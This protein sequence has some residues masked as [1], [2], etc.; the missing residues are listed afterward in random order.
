MTVP[1][2]YL[3]VAVILAL[4]LGPLLLLMMFLDYSHGALSLVSSTISMIDSKDLAGYNSARVIEVL[5]ILPQDERLIVSVGLMTCLYVG[6]FGEV[7]PSRYRWT[8]RSSGEDV[9]E[10]ANLRVIQKDLTRT[11][12]IKL[13]GA[14]HYLFYETI[15]ISQAIEYLSSSP[16][17]I[18][19]LGDFN[20]YMPKGLTDIYDNIVW[21]YSLDEK[22][23]QDGIF[24]SDIDVLFGT[25]CVDPRLEWHLS[26][27]SPLRLGRTANSF[28]SL[29]K[30]FAV[31][32]PKDMPKLRVDGQNTFKIVQL[33][34]LHFSVGEGRCRDEFPKH[35][36]CH[37]DPKTTSFIEQVLDSEKPNLVVFTGDQIMGDECFPDSTS[38]LLKVVGP[39]IER[40]IPYAMVWG[41]HDDEGSLDRWQLS[42]LA[43][44]LPYS[45]FKTSDKDTNDNT[46]GVGNYAHHIY[47]QNDNPISALYFLDAHKYSPNAKAYPGYDWIKEEQWK[48]FE[49]YE[50]FF[51]NQNKSLSMAFFHIPLPE[52]LNFQSKNSPDY[53]NPMVGNFKE[54]ITAPKYNSQGLKTLRRLGV[55]VTSSGHDHCNDFCLLDDSISPANEDKIW[56]CFGGAAGEGGYAG[57]GGTERRIRVFELDFTANKISS[58]KVL[59]SSP[60]LPFDRQVLVTDGVPKTDS[61]A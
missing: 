16:Q 24:A 20:S 48:Y 46:F 13:M 25:D 42:Q 55:K 45:M 26:K 61:L 9:I 41:N 12:R 28:V 54:G 60:S 52:Y 36:E 43:Q 38:A 35:D 10:V 44:S 11:T 14:S 50:N 49:Q 51:P 2:R 6:N 15:S 47:D 29:K 32:E 37:A 4:F 8:L 39:V 17:P 3:R 30:P 58:W 34:D 53:Q 19:A 18:H 33:A 7:C 1:K 57:Y 22:G 31:A 40:K 27:K 23:M 21:F 59:N 5:K 56:L